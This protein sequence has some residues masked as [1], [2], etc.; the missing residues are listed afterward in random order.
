[1]MTSP[2][3]TDRAALELALAVALRTPA[4]GR[5]FKN[6]LESG[7]SRLSVAVFASYSTQIDAL[8]LGP[9]EVPPSSIEPDQI[10]AILAKGESHD[11]SAFYGGALLL[12]KMLQ[13]GVSRWHPDPVAALREAECM[14]R[15]N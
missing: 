11:N 13:A 8:E 5:Q 4:T 14:A 7:E 1:M 10:A 15:P 3:E 6:K 2:T 9:H 12:K